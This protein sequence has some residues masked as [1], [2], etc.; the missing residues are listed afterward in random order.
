MKRLN[1]LCLVGLLF[2]SAASTAR[3]ETIEWVRQLGT[4]SIDWSYGVSAD[5]IGNV[6][7]SGYTAGSLGGPNA[8][9]TDAFV[10]KYDAAGNFQW[11]QQLGTVTDDRSYGVSAD[12]L[13]NVY[14]SGTTGGSLG[15]PNVDRADAFVSKYDAAGNLQW[16]QQLGSADDYS[17]SVSADALGSVY[18]SGYTS[19]SLGGPNTTGNYD[20]FVSKYDSAGTLQWTRQLGTDTEDVSYAVSADGLGSVYISGYTYGGLGGPQAGDGDAFVSKYDSAGT[21]QWTRQLGTNTDDVSNGVSADGLG[22]V[23]ISGRT[24]GSLGGP[25]AGGPIPNDAFVSKYDAAG[26]L[27][28]TRQL[29]TSSYDDSYGVTADGLGNVYLWATPTAAWADHLPAATMRL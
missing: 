18:I 8:G 25:N 3:G 22:N 11:T 7:I 28:W 12:S 17:R 14:I 10:S 13:G 20:A 26:N 19:G 9:F 6:Y 23:F 21:F 5:G 16:T 29:G 4:S 2:A 27:Q 15:G 24:R 1:Y